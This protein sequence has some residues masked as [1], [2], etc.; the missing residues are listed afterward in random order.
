MAIEHDDLDAG[1]LAT[2]GLAGALIVVAG[3]YYASGLHFEHV[4]AREVER[5]IQPAI[6]RVHAKRDAELALLQN[7]PLPIEQAKAAIAQR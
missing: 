7:G 5:T 2:I 4:R 1:L 6:D 3:S